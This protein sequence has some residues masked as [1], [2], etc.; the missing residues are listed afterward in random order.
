MATPEVT[1]HLPEY[2]FFHCKLLSKLV[3]D[4]IF[5]NGFS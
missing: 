3:E 5:S 2:I 4:T 1:R